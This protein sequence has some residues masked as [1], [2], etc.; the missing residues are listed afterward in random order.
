M[1]PGKARIAFITSSRWAAL[2]STAAAWTATRYLPERNA[3]DVC[4]RS[5][6]EDLAAL[7]SSTSRHR[8]REVSQNVV[9]RTPTS[10]ITSRNRDARKPTATSETAP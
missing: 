9:T 6:G 10:S 4:S 7:I 3:G 1:T 5:P 2:S 8:K